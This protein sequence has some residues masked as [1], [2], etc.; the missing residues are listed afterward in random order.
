MT[1]YETASDAPF[2]GRRTAEPSMKWI[3]C[4]RLSTGA[5]EGTCPSIMESSISSVEN[6]PSSMADGIEM[7]CATSGD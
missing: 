3:H 6:S 4:I 2:Q 7:S 1:S 5:S